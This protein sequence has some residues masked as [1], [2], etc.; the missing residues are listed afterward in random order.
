MK[1]SRS[2]VRRKVHAVA[3]LRF[4]DQE[5]T[6]F[7]GLVL[8]QKLLGVLDLKARLFACFRC[9]AASKVYARSTVFLQLIVHLLLGYRELQDCRYYRDDPLVQ[10][11]L[12]L[13]RLPDVATLSRM[14]KEA[15]AASV[16]P[17][18]GLL[19]EL[20][21]QRLRGLG[22]RRVT[23]D[24]DGSVQSTRRFAEG[25]AVGFNRKH[26][27]DRSYYPLFCTVAQTGQVLDLLHRSG[28]VHDSQGAQAFVLA[29]LQ[30]VGTVLPGAVRET[31]M[32]GAFFSGPML[33]ALHNQQVEFTV[34]VPFERIAELKQMVEQRRRWCP[35]D[36]NTSYFEMAWQPKSWQRRWRF[37]F[38]RTRT[39][40]R[41]KAPIQLNLFEPHL[42][43][44]EFKALVTN[45]T[46]QARTVLAFH[47]GR[48]SQEGIFA[49]LKTHCGLDYIPVRTCYGNQTYLLAGLFA[50][51]LVRELQMASSP[52]PVGPTTSQRATLWT[53][54]KL[55]TLR[56]T[57]LQRAGR[58][59][60]PG[61]TLTLTLSA[62]PFVKAQ[63]LH[64]LHALSA[65]A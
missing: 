55:D 14:L 40:Q 1:Y 49:N 57:L 22:L 29:C 16:E 30:A 12:G 8:F 56:K 45:K 25:T 53:F 28:N 39:P 61:G 33:T 34:S 47:N 21:L 17:L 54:P 36:A 4:E 60:R 52:E 65:L 19:R 62:N 41:R 48:G 35:L 64:T 50:H 42:F 59:T 44:F 23:L 2:E 26:K 58:L 31:R 43:G 10:R 38:F 27:G 24:L 46:V 7:A 63:L 6:S 18:R 9:L 5:L 13:G 37:L 20:V 3:A 11:V 15:S 51:N 32:D